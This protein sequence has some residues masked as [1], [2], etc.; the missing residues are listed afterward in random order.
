MSRA[1]HDRWDA[2]QKNL[3]ESGSLLVAFSGGCDSTFLV[4]AARRVLGRRG[5]L[6]VTGVSASLPE[7]EKRQT[8]ILSERLD[9]D[10]LFLSTEEFSNPDYVSNP[11]NRCFF[12]KNELYG[13]LAPMAE[14]RGMKIADGLNVSDRGDYRPGVAAAAQ[15]KVRHPLEEAALTKEDIRTLSRWM[16]L[17]TWNKPASPCLSSRIPYGT[18]VS[19][20][21]LRTVE[22]AESFLHGHGFF[23]VRVRLLGSAAR[24][25]LPMKDI[26]RLREAALWARTLDFFCGEG[27]G[28]VTLDER[29]FKSGRLNE[30]L[31]TKSIEKAR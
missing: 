19:P 6:A 21:A 18:A 28:E 11:T 9:V 8:A 3:L 31:P 17:P 14:R 2:L 30:A 22:R 4:A 23:I 16:R 26:P 12:C 27:V 5:M 7:E 15:W 29:A 24:I 10:H 25:E 13:R 1:L 20:G